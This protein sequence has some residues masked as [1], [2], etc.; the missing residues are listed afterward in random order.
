MIW[1]EVGGYVYDID[2]RNLNSYPVSVV[3]NQE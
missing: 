2:N 3:V 1:L